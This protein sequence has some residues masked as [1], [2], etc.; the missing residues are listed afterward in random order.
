MSV[1]TTCIRWFQKHLNPR[2]VLD[3]EKMKDLA[4]AYMDESKSLKSK[5]DLTGSIALVPN[6][7]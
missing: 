6:N 5:G 3:F 7:C 1:A 4:T 2:E